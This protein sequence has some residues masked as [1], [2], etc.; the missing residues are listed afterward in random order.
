MKERL[1][2]WGDSVLMGI[3]FDESLNRYTILKDNCISKLK[4]ML[5]FPVENHASMGCTATKALR[6]VESKPLTGG[7]LAL[8][9]F[10]NNDCDMD[11][12]TVAGDPEADH[13]P[14]TPPTQFGGQLE[15]LTIHIRDAGMQ[16]ILVVPPPLFAPRYFDWVTRGLDSAAVMVFLGDVQR[17]YRWQ[18]LYAVAVLRTAVKLNCQV[19][20]IRTPFLECKYYENLLCIDGIHPNAAGHALMLETM[21]AVLC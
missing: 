20:D 7:G 6:T 14:K 12:A 13:L 15:A 16:P 3:V 5:A 4:S 21:K 19:L 10:G 11:W 17:I 18:E 8:I 9:E 2:I 1:R